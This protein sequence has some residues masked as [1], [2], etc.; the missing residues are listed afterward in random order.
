M[1]KAGL[2]DA[3]KALQRSDPS[4][5]N[6]W[7]EY[8]DAD[9]EGVKD[10][11]R[12][13]VAS[14]QTF[15]SWFGQAAPPGPQRRQPA[16]PVQHFAPVGGG[17][18]PW[19]GVAQYG[20]P[21]AAMGQ[22]GSPDLVGFIKVG[23][24]LSVSFKDSWQGYNAAYGEGVNDPSRH[25][26]EY[27]VAFMD[28]LGQLADLGLGGGFVAAPRQQMVA[29]PVYMKQQ[30]VGPIGGG[31]KGM[32]KKRPMEAAGM[33]FGGGETPRK[34]AAGAQTGG[35]GGGSEK[36]ELVARVKAIQRLSQDSKAAWWAFTDENHGGVHDPSKHEKEVL[37]EFLANYE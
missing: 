34:K 6:A 14:L 1:A 25:E 7:W 33:M 26:P 4:I 24:K 17:C 21:M 29:Q 11:N 36:D 13:E 10:P 30:H 19:A 27:I 16:V 23:Q 37:Q 22:A 5:K 31:S 9:F 28:Y 12:H 3:V 8:C 15:L 20:A 32:G 2:V 18:N 35:G